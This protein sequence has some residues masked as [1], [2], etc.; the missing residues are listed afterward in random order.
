MYWLADNLHIYPLKLGV[1]TVGRSAD[2]DVVVPD[3]CVS[4]R[5]CAILV[6]FSTGCEL[7]DTASKNGTL[8]NGQ[9][10]S[11]P[12]RLRPGDEIGM[13]DSHLIFH[14][15]PGA[16]LGQPADDPTFSQ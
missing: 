6:H 12:A 15:R 11:T 7:H 4:R 3:G 10:V 9:R 8:I 16:P 13:C 14:A 2:N 1:N 5:H